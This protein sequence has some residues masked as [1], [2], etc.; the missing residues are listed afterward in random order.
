MS[1]EE[2]LNTEEKKKLEQREDNTVLSDSFN[3]AVS[4]QIYI[5]SEPVVH[6]DK[7]AQFDDEN[8]KKMLQ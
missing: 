4:E 6:S 5:D 8:V 2:E 1:W 7:V 3:A